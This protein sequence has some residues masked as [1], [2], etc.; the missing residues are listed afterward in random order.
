MRLKILIFVCLL[1]V[2]PLTAFAADVTFS[3]EESLYLSGSDVTLTVAAGSTADSVTVNS[4]SIDVTVSAGETFTLSEATGYK[5]E[6][7][8]RATACTGATEAAPS[9]L[10]YSDILVTGTY[11]ITP[12]TSAVWCTGS[13]HSTSS[14]APGGGGGGGGGSS[15]TVPS[16]TSISISGGTAQ[17]TS[18]NVTLTLAAT[19]ATLMMVSNDANFS[20]VTTWENY[21]TSKSWTLSEGN[22]T[23]TVYAKFRSSDG[24]NSSAVSD[25]IV[26]ATVTLPEKS[27][28]VIASGS[29]GVVALS[30]DSASIEVPAGALTGEGTFSIEPTTSYTAPTGNLVIVGSKAYDFTATLGGNAVTSFAKDL[31]LTFKYT[32]ADIAGIK[33]STLTVQYW[34]TTQSKWVSL[35]GTVNPANNTITV[36]TNHFTLFAVVGEKTS[37]ISVGDLIKKASSTAVYYVGAD[38]KLHV[39]PSSDVYKT[40]YSNYSAIKTVSDADF[41]T[42]G[43]GANVL[44]KAGVKLIQVVDSSTPWNIVSPT[45][46][47]VSK[48]GTIR[49]LGSASIATAIYG[50]SW[51]KSIIPIVVTLFSEYTAGN[52]ITAVADFDKSAETSAFETIT[53]NQKLGE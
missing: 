34:D 31:T 40:W 4:T 26:L 27:S 6:N 23:K 42:F 29:A 47:A 11:T 17:T 41:G 22:G 43:F 2:A 14:T 48:A 16:N 33:E 44:P 35:G 19:N 28:G 37:A 45:V 13:T 39:F 8:L 5:L 18:R 38:N 10:T 30:D 51:E 21:A 36:T 15:V 12:D 3:E 53:A 52:Q 20:D 7:T 1:A 32:D 50:S 49:Q 9:I 24:G 25:T 46:Y